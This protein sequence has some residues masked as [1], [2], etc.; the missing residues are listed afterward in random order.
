[1][2]INIS[3]KSKRNIKNKNQA[4]GRIIQRYRETYT[5]QDTEC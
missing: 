4:T 2:S 5:Q 1:M 3:L